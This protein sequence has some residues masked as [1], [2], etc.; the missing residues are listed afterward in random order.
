MGL[1]ERRTYHT[2]DGMRG[3][4]AIF[5]VMR[6]LEYLFTPFSFPDS[7]IAVDLFFVLSGFVIAAA[8]DQRLSSGR[9]TA[10]R[11][12]VLRIIRL[13][14]LYA[15]ATALSLPILYVRLIHGKTALDVGTFLAHV[16]FALAMLPSPF[17][18]ELSPALFTAWTLF[19]ELLVNVLYAVTARWLGSRQL[20]AI[21]AIAAVGVIAAS[22]SPS[23]LNG[24]WLWQSSW[25]GLVRVFY[26]F[27]VGVLLYRYHNR[28]PKI[29]LP[30]WL[31]LVLLALLLAFQ[32][33]VFLTASTGANT[34]FLDVA[35]LIV[36]PALVG[37]AVNSEPNPGLIGI[38]RTLG[39]TSYAIYVLHIPLMAGI[40]WIIFKLKFSFFT[41]TPWAGLLDLTLILVAAYFADQIYDKPVRAW[42]TNRFNRVASARSKPY[43]RGDESSRP[44]IGS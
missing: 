3:L 11:F 22:V 43:G 1:P 32:S 35:V 29:A 37:V 8:Y 9:L 25:I 26:S 31:V 13:W 17:T 21:A 41:W 6:H 15:L 42:L 33:P 14:P 12:F 44:A 4:A 23:G 27:P 2:L 30:A 24:G 10:L 40:D 5:V 20:L 36:L 34:L 19:F 39:I 16:P 28:V 7:F 38:F 18:A